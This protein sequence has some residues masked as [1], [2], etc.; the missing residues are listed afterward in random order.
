MCVCVPCPACTFSVRPQEAFALDAA[1]LL[2][3]YHITMSASWRRS[4]PAA[5]QWVVVVAVV[6]GGGG[7]GSGSSCDAVS[8]CQSSGL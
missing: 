7:G 6:C 5:G 4:C 3:S 1:V 2:L 8:E